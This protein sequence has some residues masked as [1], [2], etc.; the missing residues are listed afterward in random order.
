[1]HTPAGG[2]VL[3]NAHALPAVQIAFFAHTVQTKANNI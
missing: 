3:A 2:P 1:M